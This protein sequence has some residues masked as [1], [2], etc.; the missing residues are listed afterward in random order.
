MSATEWRAKL[1]SGLRVLEQGASDRVHFLL[2]NGTTRV[3]VYAP[4][5]HDSQTPHTQDELYIVAT[6]TGEIVKRG[7]RQRFEPGDVMF[8]EAGAPHRFE[9]FSV[10]FAAWVVC[11]GPT[12]GEGI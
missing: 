12:G 6:G 11:W 9:N 1:A 8:I 2:R 7:E 10:D 4:S 3:G 5:G